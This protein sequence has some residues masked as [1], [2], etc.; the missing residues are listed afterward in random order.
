MVIYY[1]LDYLRVGV[2]DYS[3]RLKRVCV[4]PRL[5]RLAHLLLL[6]VLGTIIVAIVANSGLIRCNVS[7]LFVS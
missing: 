5:R 4:P 6:T 7:H 3:C 1:D 2:A